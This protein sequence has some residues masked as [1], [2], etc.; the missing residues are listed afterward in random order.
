MGNVTRDGC[1][2]KRN[3]KMRSV[4][5]N[6]MFWTKKIIYGKFTKSTK[7]NTN[8]SL[9]LKCR[10]G[11]WII[12]SSLHQYRL[13][14]PCIVPEGDFKKSSTE[15]WRNKIHFLLLYNLLKASEHSHNFLSGWCWW[16]LVW[17][18]A[19]RHLNYTLIL[20]IPCIVLVVISAYA[21]KLYNTTSHP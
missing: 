2:H 10:R 5:P 21:L 1:S 18:I 6:N 15:A 8:D 14:I 9:L 13:M 19:F 12:V 20:F 16:L 3:A 17:I 7:W 11:I 4:A